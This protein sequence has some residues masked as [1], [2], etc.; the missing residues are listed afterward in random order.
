MRAPRLALALLA[1]ALIAACSEA[2]DPGPPPR[3]LDER[4]AVDEAE[5]MIPE[6]ERT[7]APVSQGTEPAGK[8]ATPSQEQP[9][10]SY[11]TPVPGPSRAQ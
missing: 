6:A 4:K 8:G 7:L 10:P 3:T 1:C 11:Q 5:A 2:K 9:K